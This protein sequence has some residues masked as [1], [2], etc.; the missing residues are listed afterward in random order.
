[1]EKKGGW[2]TNGHGLDLTF[3]ATAPNFETK[4]N[5]ATHMGNDDITIFDGMAH[6]KIIDVSC[7]VQLLGVMRWIMEGNRGLCYVRIMRAPSTVLYDSGFSFEYGRGYIV[8]PMED[9][10]AV[11]ISSGR[12][13]HEAKKAAALV[14]K[15]GVKTGVVDM[16]S[17][18]EV[19]LLELY[20]S[21][22]H[23]IVAEQNNGYIWV[24]FM[25]TLFEKKQNI[26]T[27][28]IHAVNTL[29]GEGKPQ[30][31]HSATYNQL[32]TRFGLSA[33]A[34]AEFILEKVNKTGSR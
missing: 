33:E 4:T 19:L 31:I 11:L 16:P 32:A 10:P 26:D 1:M 14:G 28:R 22:R 23:I 7:P 13:V 25:K 24:H 8:V 29:D 34:L 18:D 20:E 21:G 27:S 2:L 30:F 9:S 5:G 12:G 3:V 6:L 17:I 15:R